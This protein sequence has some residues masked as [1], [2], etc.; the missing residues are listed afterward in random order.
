MHDG[1]FVSQVSVGDDVALSQM[2][3]GDKIRGITA[4][5][6]EATGS[7]RGSRVMMR[8]AGVEGA[9]AQGTPIASPRPAVMSQKPAQRSPQKTNPTLPPVMPFNPYPARPFDHSRH[10]SSPQPQD[11][12]PLPSRT[13]FNLASLVV[14]LHSHSFLCLF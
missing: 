3:V 8:V 2:S 11:T 13:P 12:P 7:S 6:S 14:C 5:S 10:K 9:S 1:V 4:V